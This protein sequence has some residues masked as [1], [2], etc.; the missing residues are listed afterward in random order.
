MGLFKIL[1]DARPS[2][3]KKNILVSGNSTTGVHGRNKKFSRTLSSLKKIYIFVSVYSTS[4]V[5]MDLEKNQS[6]LNLHQKIK[7]LIT[8]LLSCMGDE[9]NVIRLDPPQKKKS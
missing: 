4:A 3:V 5:C 7:I 6:T 2:T 9:K 1:I 8:V